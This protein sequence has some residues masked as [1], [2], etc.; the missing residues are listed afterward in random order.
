MANS[1]PKQMHHPSAWL[2]HPQ[3]ANKKNNLMVAL[4]QIIRIS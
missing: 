2:S 4:T 1:W 3:K